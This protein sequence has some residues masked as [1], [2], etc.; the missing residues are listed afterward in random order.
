MPD[1]S[2]STDGIGTQF[3]KPVAEQMCCDLIRNRLQE[4]TEMNSRE[5][6]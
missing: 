6:P 5:M 4:L 2:P 3:L 1:V